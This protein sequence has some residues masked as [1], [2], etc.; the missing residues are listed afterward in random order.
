MAYARRV[1][2]AAGVRFASSLTPGYLAEPL[3]G[4]SRVRLMLGL[5]PPTAS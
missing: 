5:R 4:S 2:G 3:W 1:P